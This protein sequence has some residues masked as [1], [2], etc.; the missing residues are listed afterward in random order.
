MLN[1]T[2]GDSVPRIRRSP[3]TLNLVEYRYRRRLRPNPRKYY[4][5]LLIS[6]SGRQFISLTE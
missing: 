6:F 4:N 3:Q 2:T 5:P 1:A